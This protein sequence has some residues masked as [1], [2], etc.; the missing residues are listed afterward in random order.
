MSSET[1][2]ELRDCQARKKDSE[3]K[4]LQLSRRL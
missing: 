1:D 3:Y 4:I 2:K